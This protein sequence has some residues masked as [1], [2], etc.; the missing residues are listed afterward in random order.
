MTF[1]F[2]GDTIPLMKWKKLELVTNPLSDDKPMQL[3]EGQSVW[4]NDVYNVSKFVDAVGE[5]IKLEVYRKDGKAIHK[6]RDIQRIKNELAGGDT[7]FSEVYPAQ[8]YTFDLSNTYHLWRMSDDAVEQMKPENP[9]G[10]LV[11]DE[12]MG[13]R[14]QTPFRSPE[15]REAI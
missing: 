2:L 7:W 14:W 1:I 6:W 3:D 15:E 8:S 5:V 11:D 9:D 13:T 12:A 4:T 10:R